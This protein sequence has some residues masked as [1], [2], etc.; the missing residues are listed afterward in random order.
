MLKVHLPRP[1]ILGT[2]G[3]SRTILIVVDANR[4]VRSVARSSLGLF[5]FRGARPP[6]T[7]INKHWCG[8][9]NQAHQNHKH[10]DQGTAKQERLKLYAEQGQNSRP[11]PSTGGVIN[12]A[13][14]QGSNTIHGTAYEYIRNEKLNANTFFDH[15]RSFRDTRL[16]IGTAYASAISR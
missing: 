16:C 3:S 4:R 13:T 10:G 7:S 12:I 8:K 5:L 6:M 9:T 1:L 2:L 14:K 11:L 15:L